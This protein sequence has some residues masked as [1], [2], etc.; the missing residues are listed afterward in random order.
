MQGPV[1]VVLELLPLSKADVANEAT[2]TLA[3]LGYQD[4]VAYGA[5]AREFI[6]DFNLPF[7]WRLEEAPF[8][9]LKF[10]HADV[11]D[12]YQSLLDIKLNGLPIG[13][14]LLDKSNANSGELTVNLPANQLR[15][16]RNRLQIGVKMHLANVGSCTAATDQ[17]AWTVLSNESEIFLPY[18]PLNVPPNLKLL[19][20]PF[21][22]N[23][24]FDQTL[25]V[26]PDQFDPSVL[27]DLVQIA[28]NLGSASQ[29]EFIT[30]HVAFA[31]SVDEAAKAAYHMIVLGRP[32]ENSLLQEVNEVLPHPFEAKSD[33][34]KP[35]V[36]DSVAFLPDPN[37]D[38]GLLEVIISPW[39]ENNSLLA[40]TGTTDAGVDMALQTF[41]GKTNL[42]E[43]NLAVVEPNPD[44]LAGT[45]NQISVYSIDTRPRSLTDEE[46]SIQ[47]SLSEN[48]LVMLSKRW[49]R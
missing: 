43:G 18:N 48:D 13:S 46:S 33:I 32:T 36:V 34:L 40:I 31:T 12:P 23:T 22:Q 3:S 8:F 47:G 41:L 16:G 30:A 15:A 45:P 2:M 29:I 39:N 11:V 49:W 6:Y 35:L 25:I 26:L 24:G 1:A 10:A 4:E 42:L 28:G 37:R 5:L 44:P 7:A 9:V 19:P 38:A 21:S 17:R 14:T 27:N 20:Y